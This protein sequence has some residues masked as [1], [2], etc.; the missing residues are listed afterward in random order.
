MLYSLAIVVNVRLPRRFTLLQLLSLK[1]ILF[2]RHQLLE[3]K[4]SCFCDIVIKKRKIVDL[5]NF[6]NFL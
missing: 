2:S 1:I 6:H 3:S 4:F 5:K